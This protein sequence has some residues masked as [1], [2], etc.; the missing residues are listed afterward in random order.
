M[1]VVVGVR[2]VIGAILMDDSG[3]ESKSSCLDGVYFVVD[4]SEELGGLGSV[5]ESVVAVLAP[6]VGDGGFVSPSWVG[7]LVVVGIVD[8]G[9][10]VRFVSSLPVMSWL[11]SGLLSL[12]MVSVARSVAALVVEPFV[13]EAGC[14]PNWKIG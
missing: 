5:M 2:F 8:E 6:V 1:M 10:V 12:V 9:L 11:S 3:V 14:L 4:L 7:S 13:A